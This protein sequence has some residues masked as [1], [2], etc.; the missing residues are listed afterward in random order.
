MSL[1]KVEKDFKNQIITDHKNNVRNLN[2]KEIFWKNVLAERWLTQNSTGQFIWSKVAE[3]TS[4]RGGSIIKIGDIA[5]NGHKCNPYT[6][7]TFKGEKI[8]GHQLSFLLNFGYIPECI[9]H[10]DHNKINNMP[11]NLRHTTMGENQQNLSKARNS[12]KSGVLGVSIKKGNINSKWVAQIS[13]NG[14]KIHLGYFPT[15]ELAIIARHA[16]EL[17]YFTHSPSNF[18][19][20][21]NKTQ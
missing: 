17:K 14:K 15:I 20:I 10:I 5:G 1:A 13:V 3:R 6:R 4:K 7:I 19:Q 21:K 9:D 18:K 11:S 16:A 8:K 12:S 2:S